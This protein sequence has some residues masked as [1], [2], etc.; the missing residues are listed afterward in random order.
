[1]TTDA[2][3]EKRQQRGYEIAQK[4]EI[5]PIKEG[6]LV[7]SQSG[8]GFY[9][10]SDT[11]VCSCP[12]SELHKTTCKHA[13]AVR[14]YLDIERHTPEG[15][16]NERV[17]LTYQQAW[18]AYNKAQTSEG[19]L[20]DELLS[21]LVREIAD[22]R[23]PQT[24]GRPQLDFSVALYVAIKKVYSQMSSRR[25]MSLFGIAKEKGY[26]EAVPHFNT[27]SKILNREDVTPMLH[28]LIAITSAPLRAVESG[29]AVDS[30]GFATR[31]F[32]AY[33]EGKYGLKRSRRWLKAHVCVGVKTNIVTA[34]EVTDESGADSPQFIPL[35]QQTKDNGFDI[36]EAYGDKAYLSRDNFAFVDNLGGVPY[37][38]FKENSISKPQGSNHIWRKM[39]HYFEFNKEEFLQHYHKRS[40]VETAFSAI[41]KKLGETLKSKNNTAQVNELLCKFIAYNILVL[42]E[43]MHELGIRPKFA[44]SASL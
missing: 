28:S 43:E 24:H 13:Y 18:G 15:I 33:A 30:S 36:K 39:F 7:K 31:S 19:R 42:I 26:L 35:I 38:P 21:D 1:M 14:Y 40:N 29:F 22:P 32:G 2:I 44:S 34:I 9:R 12:D 11:F 37:V 6:W 10:V 20:F 3:T 23:I 17:R 16:K 27:M 8:D 25:S 5:K 4:K 41:K